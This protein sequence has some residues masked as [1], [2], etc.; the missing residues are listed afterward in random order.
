MTANDILEDVIRA[1]IRL[2]TGEAAEEILKE[3][4]EKMK[5]KMNDVITGVALD[6]FGQIDMLKDQRQII[7]RL[8]SN[9]PKDE[10]IS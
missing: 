3:M 5:R 7:I 4:Q 8:K 10:K 1:T 6:V 9:I 2:R